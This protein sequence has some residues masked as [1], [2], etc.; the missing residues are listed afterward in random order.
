V[1]AVVAILV[2]V[3]FGLGAAACAAEPRAL[4]V[5]VRLAPALP[6]FDVVR[7]G[8]GNVRD[9]EE[10]LDEAVELGPT[11]F[12]ADRSCRVTFFFDPR[13]DVV[14]IQVDAKVG[15]TTIGH[16]RR[17]V[18]ARGGGDYDLDITVE[19]TPPF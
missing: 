11:D 1:R 18:D 12:A 19:P 15:K 9:G 4:R 6:A 10:Y 7:V 16:A 13:A 14:E 3:A 2:L 8:L 5:T 17:S